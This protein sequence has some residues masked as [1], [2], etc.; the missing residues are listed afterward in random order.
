M[1]IEEF[2][3]D[4]YRVHSKEECLEAIKITSPVRTDAEIKASA[5]G[6]PK[7]YPCTVK[8]VPLF[9]ELGKILIIPIKEDTN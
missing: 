5:K 7:L 2:A 8:I 6:W 1:A 4:T 9:N 3:D